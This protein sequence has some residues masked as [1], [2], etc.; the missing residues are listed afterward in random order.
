MAELTQQRLQELLDYDPET[1]VFVWRKSPRS[2]WEGKQAGSVHSKGYVHIRIDGKGYKAHRLAWLYVHG[3]WP[4]GEI[5]HINRV[6]TDNRMSNLR[7]VDGSVNAMNRKVRSTNA[8]GVSGVRQR[9]DN[10]KWS[11]KIGQK[12]IGSFPTFDLAVNAR[13]QAEKEYWRERV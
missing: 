5:D 8:S 6:K 9:S 10:G 3:D 1:G 2:G 4:S 7:D 11:V 13:Q 12:Y